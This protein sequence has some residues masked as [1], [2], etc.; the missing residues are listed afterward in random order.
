MKK[1]SNKVIVCIFIMVLII[2]LIIPI[3]SRFE[4]DKI[5]YSNEIITDSD[6][7]L[8]EYDGMLGV[9]K[10]SEMSKPYL[11]INVSV[12]TLPDKDREVLKKGILI[13]DT[14]TLN[15]IIE[16]YSS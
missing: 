6:F 2:I 15:R 16:D 12:N 1:I 14:D 8:I 11:V 10:T 4:T 3:K 13:K 7:I 9:F 5:I